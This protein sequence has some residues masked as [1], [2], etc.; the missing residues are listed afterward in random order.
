MNSSALSLCAFPLVFFA[1]DLP[2]RMTA[3]RAQEGRKRHAT[4]AQYV[5]TSRPEPAPNH[6]HIAPRSTTNPRKAEGRLRESIS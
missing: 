4:A 5:I 3:N 6:A 1:E 2:K